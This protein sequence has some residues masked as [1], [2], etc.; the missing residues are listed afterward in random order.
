MDATTLNNVNFRILLQQHNGN[1]ERAQAAWRQILSL[2]GYGNVPFE[3]EGGVDVK[4]L[5]VLLEERQ[6]KQSQA[7]A[8]NIQSYA[9]GTQA[10]TTH[11]PVPETFSDL[12]DRIKKIEDLAAGDKPKEN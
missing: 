2:G 10:F 7:E 9:K 3:Y 12:D 11:Q 4:G 1:L 6:Q 5:R 8:F